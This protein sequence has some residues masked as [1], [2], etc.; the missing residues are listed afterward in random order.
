MRTPAII[1]ALAVA[2]SLAVAVPAVAH[3]G[4]HLGPGNPGPSISS[5]NVKLLSNSPKS[6]TATQSDLAFFGK[7]AVAGNYAGFRILDVSDPA[8]PV[9]VTDFRCNGPQGDVSV[10]GNLVFQSVDSPQ[11]SSACTSTNA[12]ASTPGMFEGIRVFDISDMTSPQLVTAIPT[13]C[14]S[15]TH[16][17]LPEPE[18]DRA[19]LYV[20]S[21][22]LGGAALGP[23][24]RPTQSGDGHNVVSIVEVPLSDPAAASVTEYQLEME[25]VTYLNAF[26]F[27]ACHDISVFKEIDRAAAACLGVA[28]LWDI[29][30]PLAPEVLWEFD[31]PAVNPAN[32]DLWH[33]AS[34]SWDG[35]VVAFGD[36]SGGGGAARCVDPD[37][38]QGRIWFVD[39]ATGEHLADYKIPRSESGICTMHNFN[40]V[41]RRDGKKVLVSSA[42]TGGT[43]VVDVD[44]LLA[45]AS[46]AQAEVGFARPHGAYTWSSYWYNGHIYANDTDRG[47]DVFLLSDKARA[48]AVKLDHLNPQTQL[49]LIG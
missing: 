47:M 13:D 29:S 10:V 27:S 33:S 23:N 48:G 11:S 20:S 31:D 2:A 22:P 37:D 15:H 28:Q 30:D 39:A 41:P 34:F 26:T 24:C 4:E 44:A 6:N 38:R 42:Y 18:N 1:A 17:V 12:T 25:Q 32:I 7:Y 16:T 9:T 35:E 8:A 46:A 40:F 19:I 45:G 21:Y 36:E 5:Q 14:G 3:D 43:T 49:D